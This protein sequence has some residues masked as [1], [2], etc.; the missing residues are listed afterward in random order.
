MKQLNKS[1]VLT[2]SVSSTE[3]DNETDIA[4][5]DSSLA[6]GGRSVG[7]G[8]ALRSAGSQCPA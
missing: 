7:H 8:T 1:P 6:R 2:S 3:G 5:K 4:R